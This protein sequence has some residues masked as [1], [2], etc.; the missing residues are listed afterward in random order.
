MLNQVLEIVFWLSLLLYI[1]AKLT[2]PGISLK[3]QN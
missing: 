3:K 2:Q 1:G